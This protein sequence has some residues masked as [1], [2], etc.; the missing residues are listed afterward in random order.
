MTEVV[1]GP[2]PKLEEKAHLREKF[3]EKRQT[4]Y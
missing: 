1:G 3:E 4:L 2:S